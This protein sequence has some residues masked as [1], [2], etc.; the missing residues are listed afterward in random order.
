[1]P[2]Y[3]FCCADCNEVTT[4]LYPSIR[5]DTIPVCDH[6]EG[7][8]LKKIFSTPSIVVKSPCSS[9]LSCGR[10][11]V[12]DEPDLPCQGMCH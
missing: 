1:M 2:V 12:C 9:D 4:K 8:N 5:V 11:T 6:C 10:K 3:E 7:Q